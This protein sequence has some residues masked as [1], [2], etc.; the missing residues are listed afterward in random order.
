MEDGT[1]QLYQYQ[2]KRHWQSETSNDRA[3]RHV[4]L[5]DQ[6]RGPYRSAANAAGRM[7]CSQRPTSAALRAYNG[8]GA[9]QTNYLRTI[10]RGQLLL[11]R[12][13]GGASRISS[14]TTDHLRSVDGPLPGTNVYPITYDT[15]G[16]CGQ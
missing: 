16:G 13:R 6:R 7:N 5:C 14:D 15:V 10:P 12:M 2:Y 1:T 9:R 4:N 8:G 3:E 11:S